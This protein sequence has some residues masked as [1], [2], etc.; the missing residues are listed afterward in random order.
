MLMCSIISKYSFYLFSA[1]CNKNRFYA[2]QFYM[3]TILQ[4][5]YRI[6]WEPVLFSDYFHHKL[7]CESFHNILY[8][9]V[10][11]SIGLELISFKYISPVSLYLFHILSFPVASRMHSYLSNIKA[12]LFESQPF[13]M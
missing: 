1:K 3:N 13:G 12:P 7:I 8:H 4:T 11:I 5:L 2:Q 10:H 9:I 6:V